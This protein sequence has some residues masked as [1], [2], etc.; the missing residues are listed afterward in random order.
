MKYAT[1]RWNAAS[2]SRFRGNVRGGG[3]RGMAVGFIG[4]SERSSAGGEKVVRIFLECREEESAR[5][6]AEEPATINCG[7]AVDV[8]FPGA[9]APCRL[10]GVDG[11]LVLKKFYKLVF[12]LEER[13]R[14]HGNDWRLVM[15][16][17][18]GLLEHLCYTRNARDFTGKAEPQ[19]LPRP[20][21]VADVECAPGKD[22]S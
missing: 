12:S 11:V 16:S 7:D 9:K 4:Y 8:E 2:T 21:D 19:Q 14:E 5:T 6:G 22:V 13:A 3:A 15:A 1:L 10:R 20:E 18:E 17:A